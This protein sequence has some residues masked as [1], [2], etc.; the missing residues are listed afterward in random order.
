MYGKRFF[1]RHPSCHYCL[2]HGM[3]SVME[4]NLA[5]DATEGRMLASEAGEHTHQLHMVWVQQHCRRTPASR[6]HDLL[7]TGKLV[8]GLGCHM[9]YIPVCYRTKDTSKGFHVEGGVH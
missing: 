6:S 3:D 5:G 9:G 2:V 4:Q 7:H 8:R 1:K